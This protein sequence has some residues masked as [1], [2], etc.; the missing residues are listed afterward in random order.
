MLMVVVVWCVCLCRGPPI[1]HDGYGEGEDED[2]R[3]G[4]EAAHQ[5]AKHGL[6]VEV[7]AHGGE[8]HQTPP[9]GGHS[10]RPPALARIL[11]STSPRGKRQLWPQGNPAVSWHESF[12]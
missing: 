7:V 10:Q 6:G 11:A 4:A 9:G 8:G 12:D 2:S 5:L 3:E 1:D